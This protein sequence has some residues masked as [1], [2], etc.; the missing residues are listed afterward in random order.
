MEWLRIFRE[1]IR[2]F[3]LCSFENLSPVLHSA[4]FVEIAL[5]NCYSC[6]VTQVAFCMKV[7]K[8][9]TEY[10]GHSICPAVSGLG[11]ESW[12]WFV[13]WL[14]DWLV[15]VQHQILSLYKGIQSNVCSISQ[16]WCFPMNNEYEGSLRGVFVWFCSLQ[17]TLCDFGFMYT[18]PL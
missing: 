4:V 5:I 14:L 8:Q 12:F 9:G 1:R 11:F 15:F 16:N 3:F 7:G 10:S 6:V 17:V 13:V 18:L 2:R